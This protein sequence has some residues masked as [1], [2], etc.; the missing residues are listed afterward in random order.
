VARDFERF[1]LN[2]DGTIDRKELEEVLRHLDPELWTGGHVDAV[3]EIVDS[4]KSGC[5]EY[6]EF[7]DWVFGTPKGRAS[8]D[9]RGA[10][11]ALRM[12]MKKPLKT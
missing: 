8:E 10:V 12:L 6:D 5:I 1:D 9:F 7:L 4:N 3:M 2:G 11:K